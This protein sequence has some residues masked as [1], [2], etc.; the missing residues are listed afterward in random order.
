[1]RAVENNGMLNLT[2][3]KNVSLTAQVHAH[4]RQL[5][6]RLHLKPGEAL[7]EKDLSIRLGL[8]KT[9]VREAFI[10]LAEEGL[11]DIYPQRGTFVAPIRITEIKEVHFIRRTLEFAVVRRAAEHADRQNLQRIEENLQQQAN[12]QGSDDFEAFMDHDETFHRLLSDSVTLPRVWRAIQSVKS[13]LDQVRYFI[14]PESGH[15]NLIYQQHSAIFQA[16]KANDADRAEHEMREHLDE[17]WFAIDQ[18]MKDNRD[19]FKD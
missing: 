18:L 2:L 5:I 19:F 10:R 3:D 6:L 13:Q 1:M 17:I 11:V 12:A 14:L 4:L 7:S 15:S 16:I 9:P 8:S